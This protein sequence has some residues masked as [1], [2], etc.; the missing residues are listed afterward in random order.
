MKNLLKD[1]SE[2]LYISN[3]DNTL[4]ESNAEIMDCMRGYI[5][6]GYHIDDA[7]VYGVKYE[8]LPMTDEERAYWADYKQILVADKYNSTRGYWV[9][10]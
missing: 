6:E 10:R 5:D 2:V 1:I 7:E 8:D 4:L 3:G 9:L